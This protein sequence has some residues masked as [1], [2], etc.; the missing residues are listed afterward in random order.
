MGDVTT[1]ISPNGEA[2]LDKARLVALLDGLARDEVLLRIQSTFADVSLIRVAELEQVGLGA[3]YDPTRLE[4]SLEIEPSDRVESRLSLITELP[5]DSDPVEPSWFSA[6]ATFSLTQDYVHE[7]AISPTGQAELRGAVRGGANFGGK[8]GL[9]LAFEG[10]Y[11]ASLDDPW[12]RGDTALYWDHEPQALRVTLGDLNPIGAGVQS[13]PDI[14][15]VGIQRLY[16]EIEPLRNIR[17]AGRTRFVLDRPSIVE[18]YVNGILYQTLR[19]QPGPYDLRDFPFVDGVNDVRIVAQDETGGQREIASFSQF[20]SYDLLDSG[21][22]EFEFIIG[23]PTSTG[24]AG[25]E[26]EADP[27]FTAFY[28]RGIGRALTLGVHAQGREDFTMGGV[29]GVAASPIGV[30]AIEV[31]ASSDDGAQT[32]YAASFGWNWTAATPQGQRDIGL[33][34][35]AETEEFNT[36]DGFSRLSDREYEASAFVRTPIFGGMQLGASYVYAPSRDGFS[37]ETRANASLTRSFG[38]LT[39]IMSYEHREFGGQEPEERA[40]ASLIYRLGA[41]QR[42][43]ARVDSQDRGEIAW[44]RLLRNRAGSWGA[45]LAAER[46]EDDEGLFGQLDYYGNRM[47][48]TV[49]HRVVEQVPAGGA[50]EEVSTANLNVGVGFADGRVAVGRAADRGFSI[51]DRH[52][53]LGRRRVDVE[54]RFFDGVAARADWFGP[55]LIP[56]TS[57][58][59]PDALNFVV[60]ELPPGY[61]IGEG[62]VAIRPG[63]FSGYSITV[64]SAAANTIIGI[65]LDGSGEPVALRGGW[66]APIEGDGERV[67]FFTNRSGRFVAEGAAYGTYAIFLADGGSGQ[68][69]GEVEIQRGNE[70]YV[71]VGEIRITG[72]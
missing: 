15:G 1:Y 8:R 29:S 52:Q 55:A 59:Q 23:F 13:S 32:G 27:A 2:S 25:N 44:E 4:V 50:R 65:L 48:A 67:P 33:R 40:T 68:R 62:R 3:R 71:S 54:S 58:Y 35:E 18:V 39:A 41:R 37:D 34:W 57:P 51:V 56:T 46:T 6:G 12:Q 64:G 24:P 66:L 53:T 31:A 28:R 43:R 60:D 72:P 20:Q 42:V 30:F 61:S 63:A 19:L 47:S 16:Q 38:R 14:G 45:R 21:V 22:S 17:P 36:L 26:Y 5:E 11:D 10:F 49:A 7:S 9:N 70:G 69:V